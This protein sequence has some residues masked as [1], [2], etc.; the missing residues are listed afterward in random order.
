MYTGKKSRE[1]IL[2]GGIF[3]VVI[4][5]ALL[6]CIALD[7]SPNMLITIPVV[8]MLVGASF[9]FL[10]YTKRN[11]V[12]MFFLGYFLT[13]SGIFSLIFCF[14]SFDMTMRNL[15][16]IYVILCG[17]SYFVAAVQVRRR[18]SISAVVP[19]VVLIGLGGMLLCFS[20]GVIGISFRYF[21]AH[22][23]PI[24]LVLLGF[25]LII[26]YAYMQRSHK[27]ENSDNKVISDSDE[28][29]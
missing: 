4:G 26:V 6:C 25:A 12:W 23:W 28:D 18:F 22:W 16:P 9:L 13:S 10:S 2:G 19:A 21:V 3:L 20:L 24:F 29:D 1:V 27:A 8:V 5:I 17:I 11:L 7:I 14:G 15:W